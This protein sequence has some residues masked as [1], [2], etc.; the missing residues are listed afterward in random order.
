MI[1]KRTFVAWW[2]RLEDRFGQTP[3]AD[4]YLGY[5][6]SQ[7]MDSDEFELAASAV[8][9]TA[10]FFPRPADFL[11]VQ[12]GQAWDAV[13]KNV[14]DLQTRDEAAWFAARARIPDRAWKVLATLGGPPAVLDT[15]DLSRVRRDFLDAYELT[16]AEEAMGALRVEPG[17][18]RVVA[19]LPRVVK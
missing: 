11:L 8:W 4:A 13:R 1:D 15:R 17:G 2:K 18:E 12:A 9:A 3:G 19:L 5:L 6:D 10:R 16:V 14:S 7:G